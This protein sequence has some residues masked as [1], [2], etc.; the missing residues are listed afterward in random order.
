MKACSSPIVLARCY[1]ATT[2]KVTASRSRDH[3]LAMLSASTSAAVALIIGH[4]PGHTC[5][6]E[7]KVPAGKGRKGGSKGNS[8]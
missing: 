6:K 2:T 1:V 4:H 5:G 3:A 8:Q 7:P